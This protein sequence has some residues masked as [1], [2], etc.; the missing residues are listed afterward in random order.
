MGNI[1]IAVGDM[2]LQTQ[3]PLA[4]Y[5]LDCKKAQHVTISNL[6][7]IILVRYLIC[8]GA[9]VVID[10]TRISCGLPLE[11]TRSKADLKNACPFEYITI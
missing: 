5:Y 8:P 11:F 10:V 4:C 1:R 7:A 9:S 6:T 3:K 2:E